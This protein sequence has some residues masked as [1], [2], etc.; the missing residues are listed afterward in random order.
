MIPFRG[1]PLLDWQISAFQGADIEDIALVTGYMRAA[2]FSNFVQFSNNRWSE[3]N[4]VSSLI[5]AKSWLEETDCVI[6][7]SDIFYEFEAITLLKKEGSD[8]SILYDVN[9]LRQWNARFENPLSDAETFKINSA[10]RLLEI[11]GRPETIEEIDGQYMGLLKITTKGWHTVS[12]VLSEFDE[13]EVDRLS[14]TKLLNILIQKNIDVAGIPFD[15]FWGEI[16]N[17]D[18]L[19]VQE[20]LV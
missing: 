19:R 12:K 8:I 4:M 14:M 5:C 16:D 17:A 15:G 6:S 3:T 13:C 1:R 9:W 18:D 2:I 20:Q 7:Y 11:G 10:G